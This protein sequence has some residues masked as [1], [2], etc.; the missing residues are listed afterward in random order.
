[1]CLCVFECV[2]KLRHRPLKTAVHIFSIKNKKR[3]FTLVSLAL[4]FFLS[5]SL[6]IYI[7]ICVCVCVCVRVGDV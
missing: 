7:Y 6:S 2:C 1:M 5:L 4:S 3:L